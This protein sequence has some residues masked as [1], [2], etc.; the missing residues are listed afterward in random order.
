MAVPVKL[1]DLIDGLE[2]Q[3]DEQTSY[4]D[5]RTGEVVSIGDEEFDAAEGDEPLDDDPE[6]QHDA[7]G[8]AKEILL[9]SKDYLELPSKYD[10][11]EYAIM[12]RFGLSLS[13]ERLAERLLGSIR[14]RGAFRRFKDDVHRY[15]V[16]DDW[17]R[18]RDDAMKRIAIEWC[19]LN[20]IEFVDE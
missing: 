7:I 17:Y 12:E 16:A 13:D 18:F 8:I 15:G 11:H 20:K 4:L 3:S 19:E 10:I 14:G 5:K 2:C 6:W 9:D 1:Q